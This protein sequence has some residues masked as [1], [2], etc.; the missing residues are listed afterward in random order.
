MALALG[1]DYISAKP[2]PRTLFSSDYPIIFVGDDYTQYVFYDASPDGSISVAT[3]RTINATGLCNSWPVVDG[4]DGSKSNITIMLS[5]LS[6]KTNVHIP[7][8]AG[9]NQTTYVT[10]LSR[11]CGDGCGIITAL[12]TSLENPFYYECNIT[13]TKVDNAE[14]PEHEVVSSLRT[15]AASAIALQ[16]YVAPS[17]NN[18]T[19]LQFQTYPAEF[20]YG[21]AQN[22]STHAMGLQISAFSMGVIAVAAQNN[23]QIMVPGDQPQAGL[24]LN[25]A[26]WKYVHL[27]LGLTAGL[28][29]VLVIITAL[30]SNRAIVKD[31][32]HLAVAR[33]LS[34][35]VEQ[36]GSS[37]SIAT[38]KEISDA[39]G[40]EA[41]FIYSVDRTSQSD[42]LRLSMGQQ[43]PVR[44]FPKG[45][46]D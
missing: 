8:T 23:P 20:A 26:Q 41:K 2:K 28:Q 42:L 14:R 22:G 13:V 27:I 37:G 25:I 12:E 18:N 16:G 34:P 4:G 10:H 44:R 40:S 24:T 32:S 5:S 15:L 45:L 1:S 38:G 30:V 21:A 29:L 19:D 36:L 35:F 11:S 43:K 46:Y 33:L 17:V 3:D 6:V 39:F 31:K 7:I 9:L